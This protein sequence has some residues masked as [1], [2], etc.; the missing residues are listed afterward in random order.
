VIVRKKKSAVF[1]PQKKSVRPPD[2][3]GSAAQYLCGVRLERDGEEILAEE[4]IV[5]LRHTEAWLTV[6]INLIQHN[7]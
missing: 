2:F 1:P 7:R 5:K 6:K 4:G 3:V